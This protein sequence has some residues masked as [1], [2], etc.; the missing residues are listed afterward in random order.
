M[1][2]SLQYGAV[3]RGD[4]PIHYEVQVQRDGGNFQTVVK[5]TSPVATVNEKPG[6]D[7]VFRVRATDSSGATSLWV[8][9]DP[10]SV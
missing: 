1:P 10:F 4:G 3:E 9:S 8:S 6:H 7:Y 5:T 2:L